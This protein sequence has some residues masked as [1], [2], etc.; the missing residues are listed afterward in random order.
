MKYYKQLKQKGKEIK[1]MNR[2][3]RWLGHVLRHRSLV[4]TVLEGRLPGKNGKRWSKSAIKLATGDKRQVMDYSQL[5]EL[6]QE[7]TRWNVNLPVRAAA[8]SRRF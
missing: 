5:K 6:A 2:Q 7:R 8:F 3:K 1:D 4:R